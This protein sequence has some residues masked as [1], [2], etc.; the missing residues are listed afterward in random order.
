MVQKLRYYLASLFFLL[1]IIFK[2]NIQTLLWKKSG[3]WRRKPYSLRDLDFFFFIF[4]SSYTSSQTICT[5]NQIQMRIFDSRL[6]IFLAEVYSWYFVYDWILWR[7][8]GM[9]LKSNSA[10]S[11]LKGPFT[12]LWII[13]FSIWTKCTLM[14]SEAI[15]C[16]KT[17]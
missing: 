13:F 17:A 8:E 9:T 12:K 1:S 14:S 16:Q 5:C 3:F 15:K 11:S 2:F 6:R 10:Q 7:C 4:I